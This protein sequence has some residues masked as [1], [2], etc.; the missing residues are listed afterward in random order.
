M[1]YVYRN[2][3]NGKYYNNGYYRGPYIVDFIDSKLNE[4][5]LFPNTVY[6]KYYPNY[7]RISYEEAIIIERKDK[8]KKLN[9]SW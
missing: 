2:K 3:T 9:E 8:L 6:L 7:E 4:A 1:K 5:E